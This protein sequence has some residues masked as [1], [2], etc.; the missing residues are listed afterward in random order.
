MKILVYGAG[1]IWSLYAAR[2][3]RP[4]HKVT[5]VARGQRLADIGTYYGLVLEHV[6]T[7]DR[8]VA[9]VER[10]LPDDQY[11]LALIT[12]RRDCG[13]LR[14]CWYLLHDCA[15]KYSTS[16]RAIIETGRVKT[17]V[18][19]ARS[20]NLNAYSETP[21]N[22]CKRD[23]KAL[24]TSWSA[25]SRGCLCQ[26]ELIPTTG[27]RSLCGAP[28]SSDPQWNPRRDPSGKEETMNRSTVKHHAQL[29]IRFGNRLWQIAL[30]IAVALTGAASSFAVAQAFELE[31]VTIAELQR[32]MQTG[33]FTA[34]SIVESYLKRIDEIDQNGPG[35][36]SVVELI[37]MPSS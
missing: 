3:N 8:L 9:A 37:R 27:R 11:E 33:Q 34:R 35:I 10:V 32:G 29:T 24:P 2:L 36:R 25:R 12:V 17:L 30:G 7:G 19:P 31:E 6:S 15:A 5:V 14:D 13:A 26:S 4:G 1:V 22:I 20:P 18:L 23:A 16:F 21:D 28:T